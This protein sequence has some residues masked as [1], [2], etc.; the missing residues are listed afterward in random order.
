MF[1]VEHSNV[2]EMVTLQNLK[3][4]LRSRTSSVTTS[5]RQTLSDAQY[6]TG[7]D[8][9]VHGSTTYQH[10]IFPQLSRLLAPLL[11]SRD[12]I[13]VLEIGP[14]PK[15]VLGGV[16]DYQKRKVQRYEAFE[17]NQLFAESL[18][19]WLSVDAKRPSRFPCLEY[20][21][22]IHRLPFDPEHSTCNGINGDIHDGDRGYD[23]I[24]FCHSM[25]GM[26]SKKHIIEQT[27][28][29]L[30][31][32]RDGVLA[33]FHR[34]GSFHLDGLVCH[35]TAFFPTGVVRVAD[36]DQAL[37]EFASFIAGFRMHDEEAHKL[38]QVEWRRVCRDLGFQEEG[39][40]GLLSFSS[41]DVM[42]AFTQ[43]ATKLSKLTTQLP[44]LREGRKIKNR[45]ASLHRPAA[46][47]RPT[48]I[49]H[50]QQCV[51]WALGHGAGLT[52]IGGSHS[53]HCTW[54][55]IVSIDM[56]AFRR[57][58]I[59]NSTEEEGVPTD[60]GCDT[61]IVAEAGCTTGDIIA[62]AMAAGVTVPLGSR[63]SVGAGLWLQGGIGHLARMHGLTCDAIV[64]AVVVGVDS[65]EVLCIGYV[66]SR[67]QP[68]TSVRPEN[69]TDILWALKGAGTNFGIVVSV[70][71]RAHPAPMYLVRNWAV[72]LSGCV[73]AQ[74]KLSNF[75]TEV[76]SKLSRDCSADAYL[77]WEG[78]QL[79]LGVTMVRS[80]ATTISVQCPL[81]TTICSVLGAEEDGVEFVDGVGLFETE[82]YVSR[83]HGGHGGGKTSSFKRCL[84]LRN[85]GERKVAERLVAAVEG[86]PSPLC[87]LHLLQ[88]GA[89][90]SDLA[91]DASAFGCREWD[92][93]CVITGVWPRDRDGTEV[94]RAA[95]EW[96]YS[97]ARRLLPISGGV[98]GADLGPDPRDAV[99]SR[100]AFGVNRQRLAELKI[101]LD[102]RNVLAYACPLPKAPLG[103]KLILLITGASCAGKDYCADV[104][105]SMFAKRSLTARATSIS[106]SIKREYAAAT[107][108]DAG[109]LLTDRAYKEQHRAA[110]TVYFQERVQH[111]PQLPEEQFLEVVNGA[112]D[113]GV[114][115]ITG[116]RDEAPVA[117]LSHQ[118]PNSRL[119]EVYVQAS[120]Q[121][122]R[123]RKG[124][125]LDDSVCANHQMCNLTES[126]R[127]ALAYR[128]SLI[129]DNEEHG[130][131][132]ANMFFK[133][134][135]LPLVHEDLL[136][137]SDMVR[138]T[139]DFPCRNITF[140]HVLGISQQPGGLALCTS[141][142]QSHLDGNG[143][144]VAAVA[145]CE[146]GGIVFASALSLRLNV[147]LMLVR[148]AGKLP[149]PTIAAE[150]S[151][152]H[153]TSLG[154]SS[155]AQKRIEIERSAIPKNGSI[156]VVDDTLATGETL[157]AVLQAL[158]EAGVAVENVS[159]LVVAEFPV[160]RGRQLL[161]KRGF[162]AV[163][164]RSVLTFGGA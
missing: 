164:V 34:G 80:T 89:A 3:G 131:G 157:C 10:F 126:S 9:L 74:H 96:V 117:A 15:S 100:K 77:Y 4:K 76:A 128:P 102:P 86:R 109:R 93:A 72:P 81:S 23:V 83:M 20:P 145:C 42:V 24:L 125:C 49:G 119:V 140:R 37:E 135:L 106:E 147:A 155:P 79:H 115:I 16:P 107:G 152:S 39:C 141:L 17:P 132:A 32:P 55:N 14:G 98:Y 50:I 73:E 68:A 19:A 11:D 101:K 1:D 94:A 22:I 110:L 31:K 26:P 139:P 120:G 12:R 35:Q 156:V 53:G 67:Y 2:G 88:G 137:L 62:K 46:I 163:H 75:D 146:V 124:C 158:G 142:L 82:M 51:R 66:P 61:L 59:H 143:D 6:S 38:V 92:F 150:K 105:V 56:G 69:E 133:D 52:V 134:H 113:V 60:V 99:L 123:A 104:W 90:I 65:G 84:F 63:P 7:F 121:T 71:F 27:L 149:P 8:I 148:G 122:R 111:E 138:S 64:G 153:I 5:S 103:P 87:Y 40:P 108:A 57:V 162:G 70:T 160:H 41:P 58:Y 21:P 29:L 44:T 161:R 30:G 78:G 151:Q 144:T 97:V 33:V 116:M 48:E 127:K 45:E 136:R 95:V 112:A 130:T 18:E 154:C 43:H 129:F 36:E 118:V 54:D 114:L 13:S 85:I 25:Y 159:V 28:R 47:C 91:A